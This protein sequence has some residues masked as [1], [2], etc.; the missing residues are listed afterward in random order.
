[1]AAP[2]LP[3]ELADDQDM[4]TLS[5]D[6]GRYLS[7]S[8]IALA[9]ASHRLVRHL[10]DVSL[11]LHPLHAVFDRADATPDEIRAASTAVTG[12][13]EDIDMLMSDARLVMLSIALEQL[14][15]AVDEEQSYGRHKLLK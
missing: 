11:Q 6:A 3:N 13:L 4:I 5:F 9:D 10:F 14:G 1:M 8:T 2:A 15:D 7:P 12:V